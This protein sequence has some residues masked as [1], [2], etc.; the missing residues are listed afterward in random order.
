MTKIRNHHQKMALITSI[1]PIF[2]A[3]S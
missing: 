3:S 2:L 1:R